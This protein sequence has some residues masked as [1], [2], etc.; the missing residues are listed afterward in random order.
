MNKKYIILTVLVLFLSIIACDAYPSGK[1]ADS[2]DA[3]PPAAQEDDVKTSDDEDIDGE[4][5]PEGEGNESETD[6]SEDIEIDE[7]LNNRKLVDIY[8]N[9]RLGPVD[10]SIDSLYPAATTDDRAKVVFFTDEQGVWWYSIE[11]VEPGWNELETDIYGCGYYY[12]RIQQGWGGPTPSSYYSCYW[13]P[14]PWFTY[15]SSAADDIQYADWYVLYAIH[16]GPIPAETAS[17]PYTY[18]A[19]LDTDNDSA[20]NY[21]AQPPY[22]WDYWQASDTWYTWE[23]WDPPTWEANVFGDNF[24]PVNSGF[25]TV[26]FDDTI[27]WYIPADEITSDSFGIRLTAFGHD[28]TYA[29]PSSGG[30]LTGGAPI[31]PLTSF[32]AEP[33]WFIDT[34]FTAIVLDGDHEVCGPGVC[35]YNEKRLVLRL[36]LLLCEIK[37][38][39]RSLS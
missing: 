9:P 33:I 15:C 16:N 30:D 29:A 2:G 4:E 11:G 36:S 22:N 37:R 38:E 20:N 10:W 3:K 39:I 32:T 19:V 14:G 34:D 7:T 6:E 26:I 24:A 1:G 8:D 17:H 21:N 28:G 35:K 25:R 13:N 31:E 18:A 12:I 27:F 23:T 5:G